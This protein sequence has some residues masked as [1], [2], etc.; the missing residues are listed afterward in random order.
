MKVYTRKVYSKVERAWLKESQKVLY[1]KVESIIL[2]IDPVGI[3][4]LKDEYDIEIIEILAN[5]Q[6]CKSSKDCQQLF[7]EVF[8]AWFSEQLAAPILQEDVDFFSPLIDT[9]DKK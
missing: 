5:L 2:K 4:F 7:F 9:S 6:N 1:E 8:T 3:G